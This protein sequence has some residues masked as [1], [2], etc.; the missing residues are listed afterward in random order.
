MPQRPDKTP[1][2]SG[3]RICEISG[4]N[5]QTRDKWVRDGLL[6]KSESYDQLD[7]IELV[8]LN[9]LLATLR[10][11]EAK[12]AWIRIRPQL[13]DVMPSSSLTLVWD[14]QRRNAEL[15]LANDDIVACVRH[16]RPVHVIDVGTP[17]E[18]AREA[19]RRE[20]EVLGAQ[21]D[22]RRRADEGRRGARRAT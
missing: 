22:S 13:R 12:L 17:I 6:R 16:G 9:L 5:R 11:K 10:K 2:L 8:V 15:A 7:L 14:G 19:F 20:M 4:V 21:T 18:Q 1:R 3:S